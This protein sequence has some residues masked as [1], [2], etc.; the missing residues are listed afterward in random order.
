MGMMLEKMLPLFVLC[1]SLCAADLPDGWNVYRSP[2]NST[3]GSV[4][5]QDKVIHVVDPGDEVE[6]GIAKDIPC[7]PG[8]Y[9]RISAEV[10]PAAAD[11]LKHAGISAFYLTKP[12]K[13]AGFT[14]ITEK[15]MNGVL[16]IGPVPEGVSKVR[17]FVY[18]SRKLANDILISIPNMEVSKTP[19]PAK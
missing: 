18:S 2:K 13:K 10:K 8:D 4:T 6:V 16:V 19:F 12:M 1:G 5:L 3:S 7:V 9:I 14:P 11:S 15:A 17:F